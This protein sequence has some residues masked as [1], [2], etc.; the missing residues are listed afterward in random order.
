MTNLNRLLFRLVTD[1]WTTHRESRE[2]VYVVAALFE[3]GER[4]L[5]QVRLQELCCFLV[6]L[7]SSSGALLR[8]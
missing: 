3:G 7:R 8:G 2:G 1:V 4:P 5:P 6:Q